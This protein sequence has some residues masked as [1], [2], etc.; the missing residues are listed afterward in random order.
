MSTV[1]VCKQ[2]QQLHK[3]IGKTL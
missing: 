1:V 3:H 2:F